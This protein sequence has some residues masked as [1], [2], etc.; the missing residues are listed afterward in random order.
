MMSNDFSLTEYLCISAVIKSI[1]KEL[2]FAFSLA[3]KI[4]SLEIYNQV[5]KELENIF[6]NANIMHPD[7]VP[8]SNI[9][10][11]DLFKLVL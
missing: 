6:F 5:H 11:G 8:I 7:P 9:L 1:A 2:M 3:I 4:A 10:E